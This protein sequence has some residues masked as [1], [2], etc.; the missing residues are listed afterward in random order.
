M[1]RRSDENK[2]NQLA[3]LALNS[4]DLEEEGADFS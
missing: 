1:G 3:G 4:F 2:G